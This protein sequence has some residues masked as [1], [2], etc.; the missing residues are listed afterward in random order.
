MPPF[1]HTLDTIKKLYYI[2][3]IPPNKENIMNDK[4]VIGITAGLAVVAIIAAIS[5]LTGWITM[6]TW[7]YTLPYLFNFKSITYLQGC[8]LNILC[9]MF[10]KSPQTN[11]NKK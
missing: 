5:L 1:Y 3:Y 10:F 8:A 6:L 2:K 7:N 11:N 4:V 9:W